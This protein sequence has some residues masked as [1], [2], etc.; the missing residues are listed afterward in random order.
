MLYPTIGWI[1]LSLAV[2]ALARLT[3]C[4]QALST[5]QVE[6][7]TGL[8]SASIPSMLDNNGGN[9]DDDGGGGGGGRGRKLQQMTSRGDAIGGAFP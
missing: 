4:V 3:P 7:I 2:I 6:E 5:C 8:V 9:D 1:K